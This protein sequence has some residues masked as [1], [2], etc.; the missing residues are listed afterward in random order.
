ME[1][2]TLAA[3][4]GYAEAQFRLGM[5]QANTNGPDAEQ[6][7]AMAAL[8]GNREA[9]R[10]LEV[11]EESELKVWRHAGVV[12]LQKIAQDRSTALGAAAEWCEW[13]G[14]HD[15]DCRLTALEHHID[16]MIPS[17]LRMTLQIVDWERT[18]VYGACRSRR[19]KPDSSNNG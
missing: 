3:N 12:E 16:C 17:S 11:F 9:K 15:P 13:S 5:I 6:W 4:Q 2:Y 18:G 8:Q 19:L 10:S 1:L 14:R 7:V